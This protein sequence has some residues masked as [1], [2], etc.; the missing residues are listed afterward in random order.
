[1]KTAAQKLS[2]SDADTGIRDLRARGWS[3]AEVIG[4][5]AAGARLV[6]TPQPLDVHEIGSVLTGFGAAVERM[7]KLP[8]YFVRATRSS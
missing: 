3:A 6:D 8:Q 1:M 7:E 4:Y 2:K 5:A